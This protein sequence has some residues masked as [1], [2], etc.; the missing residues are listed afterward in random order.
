MTH[1]SIIL[2]GDVTDHAGQVITGAPATKYAGHPVARVGDLVS[3]PLHGNNAIVGS[4][5]FNVDG[6]PVALEGMH[7]ACGSTLIAS[8]HMFSTMESPRDKDGRFTPQWYRENRG[9]PVIPGTEDS[10]TTAW[11][12]L[13]PQP[14]D[15]SA[16]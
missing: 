9:Q 10:G 13:S 8:Q 6:Q 16:V 12:G 14:P 5:T 15:N 2:L 3:C 4:S 7:S 1:R 11:P